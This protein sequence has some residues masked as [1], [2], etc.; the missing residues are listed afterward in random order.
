MISGHINYIGKHNSIAQVD[1]MKDRTVIVNGV[2]KASAAF[3]DTEHGP[4]VYCPCN[5]FTAFTTVSYTHL[6]R[7][8]LVR[9]AVNTGYVRADV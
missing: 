8:M 3:W 2:S 4:E 1:G 6:R 5:L 9:P 7:S